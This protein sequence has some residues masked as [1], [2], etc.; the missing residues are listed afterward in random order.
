M[1]QFLGTGSYLGEGFEGL[2]MK[3]TRGRWILSI[4]FILRNIRVSFL[5]WKERKK[6][7]F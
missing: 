5:T 1:N 7:S 6:F 3:L 4:A 2:T